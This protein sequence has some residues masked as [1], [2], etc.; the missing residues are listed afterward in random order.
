MATRLAAAAIGAFLSSW[1][2]LFSTGLRSRPHEHRGACCRRLRDT[3]MVPTLTLV[4]SYTS[5]NFIV[6]SDGSGGTLITDPPVP[7]GG[8]V[9]T[10]AGTSFGSM[11]DIAPAIAATVISG[12]YECGVSGG[13]AGD[14][15]SGGDTDRGVFFSGGGMVQLD[16][17]LSQ[18]AGVISGFDLG[19]EIGPH[20]LGFGSSYSAMSWMRETPRADVTA[21][22]V[23]KGGDISNLTLLGQYS[24][25]N[26]NAGADGHGG[27]L[28]TDP[29]AS[30][31]VAQTPL[32]VHH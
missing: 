15:D 22:G 8:T 5:G 21:P 25:A 10:S 19:D 17:L 11:A 2:A 26:F 29:P 7:G 1:V 4:G 23:D 9:V 32:V 20:S 27:T 24:A 31:S 16:A 28:F 12:G 14:T 18:F 6:T 3:A 30:S 13:A